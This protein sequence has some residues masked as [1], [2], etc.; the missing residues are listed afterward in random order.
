MLEDCK[1]LSIL[2]CRTPNITRPLTILYTWLGDVRSIAGG[3]VRIRGLQELCDIY[4]ILHDDP[5]VHKT[6]TSSSVCVCVCV[7]V[8]VFNGH[9][10]SCVRA[11]GRGLRPGQQSGFSCRVWH[12]A[13]LR[14]DWHSHPFPLFAATASLNTD[15]HAHTRVHNTC[16][17]CPTKY[18]IIVYANTQTHTFEIACDGVHCAFMRI[19]V[20]S[21]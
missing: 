16:F 21:R 20:N 13:C 17:Y 15:T 19:I 4:Y 6:L 5:S 12:D 10:M 1:N 9:F 3:C 11:E 2:L 18:N 14:S 7:C 8:D